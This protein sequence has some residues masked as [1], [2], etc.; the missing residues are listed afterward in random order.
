[1]AAEVVE[2]TC[3]VRIFKSLGQAQKNLSG[4][5]GRNLGGSSPIKGNLGSSLLET[6]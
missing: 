2:N 6:A 1:M 5:S 4:G 3:F